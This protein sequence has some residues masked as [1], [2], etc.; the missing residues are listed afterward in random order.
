MLRLNQ[1]TEEGQ[2][3]DLIVVD[4]FLVFLPNTKE[5]LISC[6]R[7]SGYLGKLFVATSMH[8]AHDIAVYLSAGADGLLF[9]P[10]ES[11]VLMSALKS[12]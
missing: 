10:Y 8:Y 4:E 6:I 2:P 3:I 1:T 11:S 12:S 5:T 9:K 7:K